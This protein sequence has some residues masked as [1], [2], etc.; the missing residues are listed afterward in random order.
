MNLEVGDDLDI[1]TIAVGKEDLVFSASIM[2]YRFCL[3]GGSQTPI[4]M[5]GL[6]YSTLPY[7]SLPYLSS[8]IPYPSLLSLALIR[9]QVL[10]ALRDFTNA[11]NPLGIV[12]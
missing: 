9:F 11:S 8:S 10:I 5:L 12:A 6:Y 3:R 7:L 2:G 1:H 4:R